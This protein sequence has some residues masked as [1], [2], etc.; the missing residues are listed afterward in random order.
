VVLLAAGCAALPDVPHGEC[1]NRVIEPH[2]DCDGV[3]T[4]PAICRPPG[5]LSRRL[6]LRHRRHLPGPHR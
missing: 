4:S 1:G 6:G 2:E 3:A 5:P